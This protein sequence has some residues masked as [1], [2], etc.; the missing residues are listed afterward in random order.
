MVYKFGTKGGQRQ[1]FGA[2][3]GIG[4]DGRGFLPADNGTTK[5]PLAE[6]DSYLAA[7]PAHQPLRLY[8][9]GLVPVC[10]LKYLPKKDWVEKLRW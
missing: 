7:A 5:I 3:Y 8:R 1:R 4:C 6:R 9:E 2:L 10:C